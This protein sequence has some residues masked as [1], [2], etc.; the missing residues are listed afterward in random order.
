MVAAVKP[1]ELLRSERH[2]DGLWHA[3]YPTAT[4]T[5]CA[6]DTE[7]QKQG[8]RYPPTCGRCSKIARRFDRVDGSMPDQWKAA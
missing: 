6:R 4:L 5:L 1:L 2:T 7:P 8:Q 3:R